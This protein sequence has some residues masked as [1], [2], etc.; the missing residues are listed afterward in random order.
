MRFRAGSK[1]QPTRRPPTEPFSSPRPAREAAVALNDLPAIQVDAPNVDVSA[2][3][4]VSHHIDSRQAPP[5]AG[6][7]FGL[8][9]ITPP[10]YDPKVL[11]HDIDDEAEMCQFRVLPHRN[12]RALTVHAAGAS[13][14][15]TRAA[16]AGGRLSPVP[17]AHPADDTPRRSLEQRADSKLAPSA[18]LP[19][20]DSD[21]RKTAA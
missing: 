20:E 6:T 21:S 3:L 2:Q 19:P 13:T 5:S 16:P 7:S 12:R 8:V 15:R 4:A 11:H 1:R 17:P 14:T 10:P 18:L 9:V